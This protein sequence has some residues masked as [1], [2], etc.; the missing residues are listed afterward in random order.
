MMVI[1][2]RRLKPPTLQTTLVL[3]FVPLLVLAISN[4]KTRVVITFNAPIVPLKWM[5]HEL[6]V[7]LKIFSLSLALCHPDLL[8]SA[9]STNSLPNALHYVR[10]KSSTCM[11]KGPSK[12]LAFILVLINIQWRLETGETVG[13]A[14]MH[15]SRSTLSVCLK[16]RTT[17][18]SL[19]PTKILLVSSSFVR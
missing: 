2:G 4:A 13:N 1:F 10:Q 16:P 3:H 15:S 11:G 6:K 18:L 19:R 17:R 12:E 7:S 9:G 8:L 5:T 14:A